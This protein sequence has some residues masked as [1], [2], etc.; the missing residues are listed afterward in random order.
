M[1]YHLWL[2]TLAFVQQ[3]VHLNTPGLLQ[4]TTPQDQRQPVLAPTSRSKRRST[5]PHQHEKVRAHHA[6]PAAATLASS[7]PTCPSQDCHAGV[8][9]TARRP[10]CLSPTVYRIGIYSYVGQYYAVLLIISR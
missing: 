10:A 2:T 9:G 4:L 1:V 8:Q 6:R 5:P 3:C 7:P